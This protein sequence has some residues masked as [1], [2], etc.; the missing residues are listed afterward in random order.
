MKN[1]ER[2]L[3]IA[4]ILVLSLGT[5]NASLWRHRKTE[6][7]AQPAVASSAMTLNAVEVDG[8]RVVLHTSGTPAYTSYSPSPTVFVVDLTG[9]SKGAA[10]ALPAVLPQGVV[11]LTAEE[12]TEMGSKL[13]R[14]TFRVSDAQLPQVSPTDNSVVVNVPVHET[15]VVAEVV[16]AVVEQHAAAQ[17]E[18]VPEPAHVVPQAEPLAPVPAKTA[19]F[20]KGIETTGSGD[21]L[22]V[23]ITSDG[24]MSY[25]AFQL[26]NPARLVIDVAGVKNA[27][28]KSSIAVND[29]TVK[30]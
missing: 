15:A 29:A 20:V 14:V 3:L 6:K 7:P 12:V 21:S 17:A 4:S 26:A 1:A 9:T 16:P 19:R 24:A 25:K 23:R 5:A 22:Q 27:V 11:S 28:K 30:G 8:S 10:L 2:I 18:T 13:T